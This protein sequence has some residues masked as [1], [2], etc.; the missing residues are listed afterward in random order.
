MLFFKELIRLEQYITWTMTAR[1]QLYKLIRLTACK[2]AMNTISRLYR[3]VY[4]PQLVAFY[5]T[6]KGKRLPNSDPQNSIS[7]SL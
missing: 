6:H 4:V 5:D 1:A 7:I 3:T 2:Q